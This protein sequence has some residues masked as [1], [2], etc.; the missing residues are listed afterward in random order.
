MI[1]REGKTGKKWDDDAA[2]PG[3][4]LAMSLDDAMDYS[5]PDPVLDLDF[6]HDRS[7]I[8][9]EG[10]VFARRRETTHD[11]MKNWFSIYTKCSDSC[12]AAF[13]SVASRGSSS[14][15]PHTFEIRI[16]NG[17]LDPVRGTQ[18]PGTRRTADLELACSSQTHVSQF[19]RSE[20]WRWEQEWH[21][22]SVVLHARRE[23]VAKQSEQHGM[24]HLLA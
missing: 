4:A 11:V 13:H 3:G 5:I 2:L 8:T 22:P 23:R 17:M 14:N 6:V 7:A 15:T 24:A 21:R 10:L 20:L 19:S 12:I 9:S 18:R 16:L 1:D